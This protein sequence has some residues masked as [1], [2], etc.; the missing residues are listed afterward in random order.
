M[1]Y[2]FVAVV[3]RALNASG[4]SASRAAL[5]A[6]LPQRAIHNVLSGVRPSVDRAAEIANALGLEFYIGPPRDERDHGT[7]PWYRDRLQVAPAT[8]SDLRRV[9]EAAEQAG[10]E[11]AARAADVVR[12]LGAE[13]LVA[14]AP[15]V[16]R[17]A[18]GVPAEADQHDDGWVPFPASWAAGGSCLALR[19]A[20]DSMTRVG[21]LDSDTAIVRRQETARSGEIVAATIEGETTLKRYVAKGATRLLVAENVGYP[22]ID[23]GANGVVVHGRVVGL[24][25]TYR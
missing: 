15:V 1:C 22:P 2:D 4:L 20:G 6:G 10:V 23:I 5:D 17:V 9:L 18:A 7:W 11:L 25:R 13:D 16:G 14:V 12:Q 3:R 8:A 19:V 21:I 24:L